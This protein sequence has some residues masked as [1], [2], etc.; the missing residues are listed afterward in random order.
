M[1]RLAFIIAWISLTAGMAMAQDLR[2]IPRA[3]GSAWIY[4]QERLPQSHGVRLYRDGA[5]ITDSV[6]TSAQFGVDLAAALGADYPNVEASLGQATPMQTLLRL[7]ADAVSA[8]LFSWF[9]PNGAQALARLLIDPSPPFGQTVTYRVEVVD[10]DEEPT[11]QV[12]EATAT[13][14]AQVPASPTALQVENLGTSVTL[15]WRYPQTTPDLADHVPLFFVYREATDGTRTRIDADGLAPGVLRVDTRGVHSFTYDADAAPNTYTVTAVDMT[16]QE[17]APSN[18]VTHQ[19]VDNVPPALPD[20]PLSRVTADNRVE[21]TWDIAPEP[22]AAGYHL[23]RARTTADPFTRITDQPLDL[24]TTVYVDSSHTRGGPFHYKLSVVDQSGNESDL[25]NSTMAILEDRI[26]PESITDLQARF[27]EGR[28]ELT[29]QATNIPADFRTYVVMRQRPGARGLN[30]FARLNDESVMSPSFT[31]DGQGGQ[32]L[33]EGAVFRYGVAVADSARNHSDTVFVDLKIPDLT[34]PNA[35]QSLDATVEEQRALR[36]QWVPVQ[37]GDA[38]TY[39]V[40]RDEDVKAQLDA[41]LT[42][43]LDED[44]RKGQA[45]RYTVTATDSLGNESLP[46]DVAEVVM[47]DGRPPRPVPNIIARPSRQGGVVV[48]WTPIVANDLAGYRIYRSDVATGVYEQVGEVAFN[49][50]DWRDAEGDIGYWYR[51][52]AVDTSGNESRPSDHAEAFGR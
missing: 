35:P 25:S 28:V 2:V 18:A 50:S 45:Y 10:G 19:A 42:T 14:Q 15:T 17:S 9:Y 33:N 46:S 6:V 41:A 12:L 13:L 3:D 51:V 30:L 29:W 32:G 44:V 49:A 43:W 47:R 11:G 23:H 26:I 31:D 21:L 7:R 22:D 4:H 20:A 48:H 34:P 36:L 16:R 1:K 39:T 24:L 8:K 38:T 37:A 40:Y 5:L 27:A 52:V